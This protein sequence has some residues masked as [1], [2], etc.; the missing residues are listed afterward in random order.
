MIRR[1]LAALALLTLAFA[2]IV[3]AP[4]LR[5]ASADEG[6]TIDSF[7]ADIT[8]NQD[9]SLTIVES[10]DVDFGAQQKHGIFREI[11]IE[12]TIPGDN[13]H[14]RIYR[15]DLVAVSR[16][17][18]TAWP[19]QQS[20]NG[21]NVRLKIGDPDRTISGKQS[22]RITYTVAGAM[23]AF[24]DHDELYWNVNG[25]DWPVRTLATTAD[26]HVSGGSVTRVA[27]YE[28][29]T[30]STDTCNAA[31]ANEFSGASF[32]ATRPFS[33]GEQMT[34]VAALPKGVVAEP[35][36]IL[37]DKPKNWFERN[38]EFSPAIIGAAVVAAIA[39]AAGAVAY[40]WRAG[41]DRTYTTIYYLSNDS[42]EQRRPL[43][44]RDQVVVEYLPPDDLLPAQMGVLLDERADTKDVTATIVDLAVRG[45]LTIEELDKSWIFGKKDW[46]LTKKK[47]G[48]DLQ[49]YERTILNGLFED[50]PEKKVSELKNKYMDALKSAE[51]ELY[52][53][54][55]VRGWFAGNPQFVRNY[56]QVGG[57]VVVAAAVGLGYVL[58]RFFGAA[59]VAVPIGVVGVLLFL[60][61]SVMPRRT[62]KGS[63]ALRRVLGFRLYINTAEQSRQEFNEKAN[64]FAKY[65]PYAIV[66]GAVEKWAR[67]FRDIDTTQATQG[68]YIG[69]GPFIA[70]DF[71]NS[72][73]AFS[74]SVSSVI[75][76]TP[77]SS[78]GSGFSGGF[79]GGGGGGGGGGSW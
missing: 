46:N 74:S 39:A 52:S 7:A 24:P 25:P 6:W 63:E 38:F 33:E 5:S 23:N 62:A 10:I 3:L 16:A 11:P 47:D 19:V 49:P 4:G 17:D 70:A 75:G 37:T 64:I 15:F 50:G 73:Q 26:V 21:A 32:A 58:G 43:F 35:Q 36:V 44:H 34:I 79:S 2:V 30:G 67:V 8:I 48:A 27:C 1:R 12:Y 13:K 69:P 29:P 51:R 41:R 76:S 66:F 54:A 31:V 45:Y 68:W 42:T 65:L 18:G 72:L 77:G 22:Y 9:A 56:A 57:V 28:G 53:D 40:W 60:L 71:S 61:A 20:R 59:L 14:D 55:T 78:G